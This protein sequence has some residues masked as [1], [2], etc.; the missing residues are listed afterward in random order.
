MK[1]GL[2]GNEIRDSKHSLNLRLWL[3]IGVILGNA[4]M[5]TIS[6]QG[7]RYSREST[8]QGVL[9]N[10]GNL[11]TLLEQNIQATVGRIDIG[12]RTVSD[13]LAAFHRNEVATENILRQQVLHQFSY[14][15]E[16]DS[17]Q[18]IDTNGK[19]LWQAGQTKSETSF[20][21]KEL[22]EQHASA[23]EKKLLVTPPIFN[24]ATQTWGIAFARPYDKADHSLGGFVVA[25]LP[26]SYLTDLIAKPN[27]GPHGSIVIRHFNMQLLTRYPI[28]EGEAGKVGHNVVSQE[29]KAVFDSG[30]ESGTFL[31]RKAPDGHER[32][33]AFRRIAEMPWV[34]TVGMAPEDTLAR[35]HQEV[36]K[37]GILV[38]IL[39]L[40]SLFATG[41]IMYYWRQ[42]LLD[43]QAL[44]SAES[45][46]REELEAAVV[47]RT[48]ELQ[49]AKEASEV[50]NAAK[51]SF[52]ANMSHEIRTPIN[53]ITGMAYLIR[54]D[55][56]TQRKR[57]TDP[58]VKVIWP[59][60][61]FDPH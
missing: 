35:W 57:S 58:P 52:L 61:C 11:A 21:I 38:F 44:L 34:L 30:A 54:R 8:I 12:L 10:T 59:L 4:I 42:H 26:V 13:E 50:A 33:Y 49:V 20:C 37:T 1:P 25:L 36:K 18:V 3:L 27:L 24:P 48:H 2:S 15:Q 7:L 53:A 23:P 5:I 9:D 41:L 17:V 29:F 14:Q 43:T 31:T 16:I 19:R 60:R 40:G 6:V 56:L 39:V 51:S 28:V 47:K 45:R 32:H 46:H 22:L 55:G